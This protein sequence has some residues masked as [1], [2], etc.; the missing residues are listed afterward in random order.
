M[1]HINTGVNIDTISITISILCVEN[2]SARYL[3]F[4][5]ILFG[6]YLRNDMVG[7]QPLPMIVSII[8]IC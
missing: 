4:K 7:L 3:L 8:F 6:T 2:G 5:I 1:K